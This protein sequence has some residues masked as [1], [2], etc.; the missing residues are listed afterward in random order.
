MLKSRKVSAKILIA[1]L[2]IIVI[3]G[4]GNFISLNKFNK[5]NDNQAIS[6]HNTDEVLRLDKLDKNLLEIRGDLLSMVYKKNNK[7][8]P[9]YIDNVEKLV[10]DSDK[11]ISNY[12]NSEFEYLKGEEEIFKEFKTSYV[13]YKDKIESIIKLSQ[14]GKYDEAEKE[15][16]K[17][18]KIRD[19]AI[20]DLQQIVVMNKDSSEK[21]KK[22]NSDLFA[23][24]KLITMISS[25]ISLLITIAMGLYMAKS[26]KML[27]KKT[28]DVA[29]SL[30]NYDLTYEIEVDRKDEFGDTARTLKNVQENL[31]NLV[32]VI[33]DESQDLSASSQELSATIEEL[34]A[35]FIDV[36]SSTGKITEETQEVSAST[37]EISASIE[38]MNSN[39]QELASGSVEGNNKAYEIKQKAI[40]TKKES[41][42]SRD[43]AINLYHEKQKNILKAIEDGKV[44][45]EIKVMAGAIAG[46]A[47][48]TNLLALNAAIEAAR[49]GEN[50]RGFEVVAEE[51]RKLAEESSRTI[52]TIE[53]TIVEVQQ[54]FKNLSD[55]AREVLVFMDDTVMKDYDAFIATLDNYEKDANFLND[56]SDNIASMTE[57]ITAT[58]SELNQAIENVS[59]NAQ[60]S[61][62]NTVQIAEGINEMTEGVEQIASTA[63]LQAEMA[64]DLNNM[65]IKFKIS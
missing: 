22:Q 36:D 46:I 38:D 50:G 43:M 54:A 26:I 64:Q 12:E 53:N 37:E 27:L 17:A 14:K 25:T 35:K 62:E 20:E 31:K 58:M 56:M 16:N 30:A 13:Q 60:N 2:S 19:I 7:D 32:K 11:L 21:I 5:V 6:Y 47:E 33:I 8:L 57:E 55:N 45:E 61:S 40:K 42:V 63:E 24:S 59:V 23:S 1:F 41:I 65:V 3:G 29:N 4:I 9:N 34:N 10:H 39:M 52:S 49:A 51:V 15:Y 48:Q 44:V 18:V 28:Q